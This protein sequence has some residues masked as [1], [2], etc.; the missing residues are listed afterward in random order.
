MNR[1]E[2]IKKTALA[3]G[4]AAASASAR[5][6]MGQAA[7]PVVPGAGRVYLTRAQF[8]LVGAMADRILPQSDTPGALD[9][10]VPEFIDVTFGKY[11]SVEE[12]N[13][14]KNGAERMADFASLSG[15]E[16]DAR[17]HEAAQADDAFYRS[18][19]ELVITGYFTSEKVGK[20]VLNYLPI[21]GTFEPCILLEEVG[22]V[23]WAS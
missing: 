18:V 4:L 17:L 22:N 13:T 2:A 12:V 5:S 10:G 3:L 11:F 15:E 21:P 23:N 14:F 16:Q 6:A 19:R 8:K 1:R 20:E 9:V 7:S